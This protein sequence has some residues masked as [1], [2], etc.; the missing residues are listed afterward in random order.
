M[1]LIFSRFKQ[2]QINT[3]QINS[4]IIMEYYLLQINLN[5]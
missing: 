5:I 4:I 3:I 1:L 2:C